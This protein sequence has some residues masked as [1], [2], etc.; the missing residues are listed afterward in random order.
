MKV[1]PVFGRCVEQAGLRNA[2]IT[3]TNMVRQKHGL[4]WQVNTASYGLTLHE[5][6]T[7]SWVLD[8]G[9]LRMPPTSDQGEITMRDGTPIVVPHVQ[10]RARADWSRPLH[11]LPAR[12]PLQAPAREPVLVS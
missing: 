8:D 11:R 12:L 5:D 3:S 6:S 7:G 2:I 10:Q 1:W 4:A 9:S